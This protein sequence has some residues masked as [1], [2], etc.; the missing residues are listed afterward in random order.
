MDQFQYSSYIREEAN[1]EI[2]RLQRI[3]RDPAA[4]EQ[5]REIAQSMLDFY[6]DAKLEET[7]TRVVEVQHPPAPCTRTAAG[8]RRKRAAVC[9]GNTQAA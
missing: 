1:H 9:G 5:D 3:L 6:Q 4:T 8:V 2:A 7:F